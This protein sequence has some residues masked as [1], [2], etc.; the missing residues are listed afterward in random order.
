MQLIITD[1][2]LIKSRAFHLSG[3][4]LLLA[5]LASSL[6]LMS[7]SAGLYHWVFLKGARE[8]WPIVG[9]LVRLVVKDEV[10]QQDRFMRE[11]I[12]VMAKKLG[13][14]QAKMLQLESLGE[15]IPG[16]AGVSPAD[17][18]IK[19]GQGG[20]LVSGR[21][22]TMLELQATLQELDQTAI[23]RTDLMT[24]LESRLFE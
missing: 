2:W 8:G 16:L 14:M 7:V 1:A 3:S 6:V 5:M 4:K 11:N 21:D 13:E 12:E 10:A 15:R 22:L 23:Q 19:P 17:I 18:K 9:T 24:V 20:K